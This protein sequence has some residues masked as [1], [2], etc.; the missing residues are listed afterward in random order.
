LQGIDAVVRWRFEF[1]T[2]M[3]DGGAVQLYEADMDRQL[4]FWERE[5]RRN[6][7]W[8]EFDEN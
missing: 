7:Q 4:E 2:R 6:G 8:K 1:F 5:L 3:G